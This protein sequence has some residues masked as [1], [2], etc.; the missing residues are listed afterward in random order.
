MLASA[1]AD[2]KLATGLGV[3]AAALFVLAMGGVAYIV[4]MERAGNPIFKPLNEGPAQAT[5]AKTSEADAAN[6]AATKL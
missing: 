5:D 6:M 3:G 4:R 2:A 1:R